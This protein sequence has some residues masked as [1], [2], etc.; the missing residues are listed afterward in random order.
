MNEDINWEEIYGNDASN[1]VWDGRGLN[2]DDAS[3]RDECTVC[4]G[5]NGN[6]YPWCGHGKQAL[7]RQISC[8]NCGGSGVSPLCPTATCQ[9]CNGSGVDPYA[10]R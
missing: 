3:R 4:G 2:V 10:H 7:M 8:G 6:H 9:R 5:R 1:R